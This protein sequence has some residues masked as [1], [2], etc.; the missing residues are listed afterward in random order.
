MQI[1]KINND[2]RKKKQSR[3]DAFKKC[4]V[5]KCRFETDEWETGKKVDALV[6]LN[7]QWERSG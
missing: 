4:F 3:F 1:I 6:K 7:F 2:G 5:Q